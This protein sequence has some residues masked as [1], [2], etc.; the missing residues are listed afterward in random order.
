[1]FIV[2]DTCKYSNYQ[3]HGPFE[4][5]EQADAFADELREKFI[6]GTTR[7]HSNYSQYYRSKEEATRGSFVYILVLGVKSPQ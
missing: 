7:V 2:L 1:M 6:R 5:W 4:K 3:V